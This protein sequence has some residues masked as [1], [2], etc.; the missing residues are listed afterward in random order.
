MEH[1]YYDREDG[2]LHCKICGGGEGTLPTDCPRQRMTESENEL[3]YAGKLDYC[4][5][6]WIVKVCRE[7]GSVH[8]PGANTLC[9]A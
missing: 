9:G 5:G 3:I 6:V 8:P 7:C 4:A 2:L 1:E